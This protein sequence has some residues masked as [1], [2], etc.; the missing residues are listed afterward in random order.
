MTWSVTW[1]SLLGA[2]IILRHW[3]QC[4]FYVVWW[5]RKLLFY[6]FSPQSRFFLLFNFRKTRLF[7]CLL[8]TSFSQF[9]L[10]FN[11]DRVSSECLLL[12]S[13]FWRIPSYI[14]CD[15]WNLIS[16]LPELLKSHHWIDRGEIVQH[17]NKQDNWNLCKPESLFLFWGTDALCKSAADTWVFRSSLRALF[18]RKKNDMEWY[19]TI[20]QGTECDWRLHGAV[21][22]WL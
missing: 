13:L 8:Y 18:P 2:I 5:K 11:F 10:P 1:C 7:L 9:S 17:L 14:S 12:R 3:S 19:T 20:F 4:C 21:M 6:F 16:S 15:L 22:L